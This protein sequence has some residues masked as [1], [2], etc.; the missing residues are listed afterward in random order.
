MT[1][2]LLGEGVLEFGGCFRRVGEKVDE[3]VRWR[4]F[5]ALALRFCSGYRRVWQWVI[6]ARRLGLAAGD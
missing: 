2:G 3:G 6:E 4:V 1:F 5:S